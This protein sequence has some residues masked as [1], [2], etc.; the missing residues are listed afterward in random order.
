MGS[1]IHSVNTPALVC[2]VEPCSWYAVFTL[3]RHEK[4]VRQYLDTKGIETFLPLRP[5]L[6]KWNSGCRVTVEE[7]AAPAAEESKPTSPA[8]PAGRGRRAPGAGGPR[9][10]ERR[11]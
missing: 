8:T 6:R 7:P 3:P 5:S 2:P 11:E 9:G 4:R 10:V 1:I